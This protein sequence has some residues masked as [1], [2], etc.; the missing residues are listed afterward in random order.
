MNCVLEIRYFLKVR[1]VALSFTGSL[2]LIANYEM[3]TGII[4]IA[5]KL[6][7]IMKLMW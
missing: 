3:Y 2:L 7:S 6:Y 1:N 5:I 4:V